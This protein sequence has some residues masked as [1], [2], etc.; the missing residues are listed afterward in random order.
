MFKLITLAVSAAVPALS[1]APAPAPAVR[2][3][4]VIHVGEHYDAP[5]TARPGDV[6]II[7]MDAGGDWVTRCNDMGG[8]PIANPYTNI[9]ECDGVDF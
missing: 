3:A 2:P 6:I 7:T 5:F 8:E 4:Q 9:N 1:C